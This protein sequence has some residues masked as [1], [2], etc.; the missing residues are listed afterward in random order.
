MLQYTIAFI[1]DA[2]IA[3]YFFSKLMRNYK[4][5]DVALH[6]VEVDY[7][8]EQEYHLSDRD[9]LQ[10]NIRRRNIKSLYERLPRGRQDFVSSVDIVHQVLLSSLDQEGNVADIH[11]NTREDWLVGF[12]DKKYKCVR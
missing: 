1:P 2:T 11:P 9:F 8:E 3:G 10:G 7:E 5:R 12:W 4:E 6:E